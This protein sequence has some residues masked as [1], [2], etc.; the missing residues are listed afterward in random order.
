M[1]SLVLGVTSVVLLAIILATFLHDVIK[2]SSV[3]KESKIK[4]NG[5]EICDDE[6]MELSNFK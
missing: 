5:I 2:A 3:S 1:Y 4:C 6:D